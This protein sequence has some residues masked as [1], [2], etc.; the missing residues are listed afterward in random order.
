PLVVEARSL[1]FSSDEVR[2]L[3]T[4][5][6]AIEDPNDQVAVLGAL[7]HPAF[8]C[9]DADLVDWATAGHGWW[10]PAPDADP[11][12]HPVGRALQRLAA[13][14]GERQHHSV[15]GF[16]ER[17]IAETHLTE[18]ALAHPR[19]RDRWRRIRFVA[20]Q[21]HAFHEAGGHLRGFVRWLRDQA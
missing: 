7:R 20:D 1:I 19:Y 4:I 3:T 9:S 11:A 6:T 5:L 16:V 21:A 18:L 2:D 8:G 14:R 12:A 10:L 17:V 15:G 13:L